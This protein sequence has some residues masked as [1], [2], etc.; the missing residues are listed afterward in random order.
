MSR[1]GKMPRWQRTFVICGMMACSITGLMYLLGHQFQIQRSTLGTHSI[2]AAHGIAA[3]LATLALGSVMPFHIKVGYK[4]R[5]Q[6]WSGFSQLGFLFALL[7]TGGM[8]YYGPEEIRDTAID[9]HWIMG[10]MFA[11]I[12]LL[13]LTVIRKPKTMVS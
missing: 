6:L 2:L 9:T 5:K 3:M 8:L 4:S 12:F 10:L 11:V 13:H 7:I 1:L